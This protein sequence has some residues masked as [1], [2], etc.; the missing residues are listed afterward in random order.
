MSQQPRRR[1]KKA[2]PNGRILTFLKQLKQ[3][4]EGSSLSFAVGKAIKSIETQQLEIKTYVDPSLDLFVH[5]PSCSHQVANIAILS[6]PQ[7]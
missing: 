3:D 4:E 1:K 2:S 7:A 5:A 6:L